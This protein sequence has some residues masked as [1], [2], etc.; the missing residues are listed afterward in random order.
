[1]FKDS[2]SLATIYPALVQHAMATFS[3][4]DVMRFLGRK[5]HGAYQGEIVSDFKDRP[6]GVRI[7]HRAGKNS[8]K[9]YDKQGSI[10][11]PETT[12][13]NPSD[14][15]VYRRKEGDPHGELAWR[16]LRKGI[17][18]LHRRAQVSQA[19]NERYLDALAA[20]DTSTPLGDLL[21]PLCRP[22]TWKGHRVRGLRA[23]SPD[24][25]GLFQAI[26]RGEF[27][28]NGFR[29][30]DLQR[31]LFQTPAADSKQ[32]R[33]RSAHITRRLRM[34]RA[35][36]LIRKVPSSRRYLLT[37]K[38]REKLYALLTAQRATLQQLNSCL[39]LK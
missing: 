14:F 10:M 16:P 13:N 5:V 27:S 9:L 29:N 30:R 8:V 6:E 4:A 23:W 21:L 28:I 33:R 37:H 7:K 18:D 2:A 31:L 11:R 38:G 32:R 20:A 35:H 1:M 34:L 39:I 19:C 26:C 12:I 3:S 36:G 25:L 17:A 24:D 15:K 22:V